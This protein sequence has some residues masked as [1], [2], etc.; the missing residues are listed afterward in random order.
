MVAG[1]F[2]L[3]H[4]GQV[5]FLR[6][7]AALG[8]LYVSLGRDLSIVRQKNKSPMF[9]EQ[10]RKF[11]LENL[12]CVHWVGIVDDPGPLGFRQHLEEIQPN[13]FVIN[14]DGHTSD[15]EQLCQGLGVEYRVF[16]RDHFH[17]DAPTSATQISQNNF[18]PTRV[19]LCSGF[20]DNP[21]VNGRVTTR[22]GSLV[23]L[24]IA[25]FDG[26]QER[27]G[28]ATS[29]L[30]TVRKYF[31]CRLPTKYPVDQLAEM[32][33]RLENPPDRRKYISG[34][35]DSWGILSR[36][37]NLFTYTAG[38]FR[39]ADLEA[40]MDEPVLGWL[41]QHLYLKHAWQRPNDCIVRVRDDHPEFEHWCDQ[42][43]QA[44]LACWQ[45]IRDRD[46]DAL[47][48]AVR[49][50]HQAQCAVV[51][52]HRPPELAEFIRSENAHAAM[53]MGAGGGGYVCFVGERI[54][55][56]AIRISIKRFEI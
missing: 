36:G 17:P 37:A 47:A 27:S 54:P 22:T 23:V 50:S 51:E 30:A 33:F 21:V 9:D 39:P 53:I 49:R 44:S 28:M 25:A 1:C 13:I 14:Q 24:P 46:L 32:I 34:T 40:I 42:L 11:M 56:D 29:T 48:A 26:L 38:T 8:R 31:G 12:S 55:T 41:E 52:N 7:A 45:A 3:L 4:P 5:L 20:M 15:K 6:K 19:S 10:E 18:I 35:L 43:N 16:P 2:D